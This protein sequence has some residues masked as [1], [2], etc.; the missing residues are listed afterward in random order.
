M[1]VAVSVSLC[2]LIWFYRRKSASLTTPEDFR[3][4]RRQPRSFDYKQNAAIK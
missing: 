4:R 2:F 3:T 1:F